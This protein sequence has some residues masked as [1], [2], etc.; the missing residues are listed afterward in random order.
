MTHTDTVDTVAWSKPSTLNTDGV[1]HHGYATAP[2]EL[3]DI[4]YEAISGTG[5]NVVVHKAWY[6]KLNPGGFIVPHVDQGPWMERWH[7]PTSGMGVVWQEWEDIGTAAVTLHTGRYRMNHHR[8]HAVWNP[9]DEP[10]VVLIV[11]SDNAV[12]QPT[13]DLIS[14]DMIPEVQEMIDTL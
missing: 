12:D 9:F 11:E 3:T 1:V 10:R 8:P 7:I 14:C 13:T 6:A 5:R 2:A 4:P